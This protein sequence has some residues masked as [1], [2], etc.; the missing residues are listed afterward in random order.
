MS[1]DVPRHSTQVQPL[2]QRWNCMPHAVQGPDCKPHA[3]MWAAVPQH[4][5][6]TPLAQ[7]QHSSATVS[8]KVILYDSCCWPQEG[9]PASDE[10]APQLHYAIETAPK[11]NHDSKLSMYDTR[12]YRGLVKRGKPTCGALCH[13]TTRPYL[14]PRHSTS[15]QW[16]RQLPMH[17][18][19]LMQCG[20]KMG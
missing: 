13:N 16:H 8:T 1:Y 15:V 19:K 18:R 3:N 12:C 14:S 9:M 4:H 11:C 10:P 17:R 6:A 5:H 7:A 2:T 20:G